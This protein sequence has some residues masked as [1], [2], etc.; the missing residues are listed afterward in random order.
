MG[1]RDLLGTISSTGMRMLLELVCHMV[2]QQPRSVQVC[3]Y[4]IRDI[5][6]YVIRAL[7]PYG[8]RAFRRGLY[9]LLETFST[10]MHVLLELVCHMVVG[11]SC[12]MM[13]LSCHM[14]GLF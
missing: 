11:L 6:V 8:N 12:H 9:V 1:E 5:N 14:I 10:G 13:D 7:L 4:V 3:I 2:Q